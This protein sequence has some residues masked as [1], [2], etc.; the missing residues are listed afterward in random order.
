[1]KRGKMGE[2]IKLTTKDGA[3]IDAYKALPNGKPRGAI[4]VLQEV[5]GV[6]HHIRNVADRFAAEGY[7]AIAP[8]LFDRVSPGVELDYVQKDI[9]EGMTL[10]GRLK[11]ED[12]LA[13]I[14][15]AI[16]AASEA[17]KVGVVGYCWGGALAY[18]TAAHLTGVAA[19]V[20]YYGG[21][22]AANIATAFNAPMIL[23]F[24]E[25]DDHIPLADVEKIKKANPNIPVHLYP[26]GHGFN[27]DERGSYDAASAKLASERTLA[28]FREHLG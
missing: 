10:V 20:G 6:N 12:T 27:C 28:F 26:A 19:A 3:K 24:G 15:A 5:F 17:G 21:G 18:A 11:R 9:Q 22:I 4:V 14:A 13:D 1:M 7:L 8:A 25:R 23:H 2:M 16:A